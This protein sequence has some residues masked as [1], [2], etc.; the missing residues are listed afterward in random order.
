MVYVSLH[1]R[2]SWRVL[3][4]V[5][6]RRPNGVRMNIVMARPRL[7]PVGILVVRFLRN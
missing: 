4:L 1:G 5:R 7:I 2:N 3:M 6:M